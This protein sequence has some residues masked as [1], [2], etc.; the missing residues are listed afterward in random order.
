MAEHMA[1]T[2]VSRKKKF[3]KIPEGVMA[4]QKLR[5]EAAKEKRNISEIHRKRYKEESDLYDKMCKENY[6]K[7]QKAFQEG[8]KR[9]RNAV[10]RPL[11]DQNKGNIEALKDENDV[12]QTS[13]SKVVEVHA[14]ALTKIIAKEPKKMFRFE[15]IEN[16]MNDKKETSFS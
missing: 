2:T 6:T 5:M 1:T 12:L 4:D 10:Y 13:P 9:D 8:L 11:K 14:R 15:E 3:R 16:E 7:N